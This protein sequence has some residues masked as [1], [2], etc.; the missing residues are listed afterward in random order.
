MAVEWITVRGGAKTTGDA[1]IESLSSLAAPR[2]LTSLIPSRSFRPSAISRDIDTAA[3]FI[4]AEAA[5]V[6]VAGSEARIGTVF[7]SLIIEPLPEAEALLLRHS[8]LCPLGGQ[9][10]LW[11]DG[12]LSHPLHHVKEPS[13][14][15][16]SFS[17]ISYLPCMFFF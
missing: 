6:G 7:G 1:D 10:A 11:P 15:S 14:F 4:G 17:P 2:P 9:G 12:G 5:L 3:K 13:P 16:T 8:G